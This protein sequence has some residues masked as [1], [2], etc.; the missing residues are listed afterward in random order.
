MTLQF[1]LLIIMTLLGSTAAYFLKISSNN[2]YSNLLLSP[3]LYLGGFLYFLSALLNIFLLK[4]MAYSIVLPLTSIT[5]VWT[6]FI[7]YWLLKEKI[8][9]QK[10]IGILCIVI[11]AITLVK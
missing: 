6:M 2:N 10:I 3:F 1:F 5:Y 7:S 9:I 4:S 11:G 8:T